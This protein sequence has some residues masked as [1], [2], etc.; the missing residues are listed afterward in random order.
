MNCAYCDS[1][2]E[3]N[4]I[5]SEGLKY[6]SNCYNELREEK[7]QELRDYIE[8]N[9]GADMPG[10]FENSEFNISDDTFEQLYEDEWHKPKN[11]S[12]RVFANS[13]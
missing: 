8:D 1:S 7:I 2:V 12:I 3:V 11:V 4:H 13:L 5:D 9:F 6:C 10:R